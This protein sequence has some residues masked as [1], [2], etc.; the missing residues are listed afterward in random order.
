MRVMHVHLPPGQMLYLRWPCSFHPSSSV[1]PWEKKKY[2]PHTHFPTSSPSSQLLSQAPELPAVII[3]IH[4]LLLEDLDCF[5][6]TG[7]THDTSQGVQVICHRTLDQAP[8]S[9]AKK[10]QGSNAEGLLWKN[11]LVPL[12]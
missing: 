10:S 2:P 11:P 12:K 1:R 4:Q 9:A 7:Y 3:S 6:A 8:A 5:T